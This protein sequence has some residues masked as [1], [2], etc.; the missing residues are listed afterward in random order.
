M[1]IVQDGIFGVFGVGEIVLRFMLVVWNS[2]E[3]VGLLENLFR[4]QFFVDVI[5]QKG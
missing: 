5:F 2:R 4:T 3:G 1:R